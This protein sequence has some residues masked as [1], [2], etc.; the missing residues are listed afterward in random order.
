MEF[1]KITVIVIGLNFFRAISRHVT[2]H[3]YIYQYIA[4]F[5]CDSTDITK[6]ISHVIHIL[7]YLQ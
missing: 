6:N 7:V 4:V 1:S 3:L 2:K 5:S